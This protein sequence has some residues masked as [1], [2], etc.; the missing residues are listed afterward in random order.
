MWGAS[1]M[2]EYAELEME[3]IVF[4]REDV[5]TTSVGDPT[6]PEVPVPESTGG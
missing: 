1:M 2:E 5:I 3:V 6:L 4:D